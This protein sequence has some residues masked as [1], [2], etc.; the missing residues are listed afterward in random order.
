MGTGILNTIGTAVLRPKGEKK[1]KAKEISFHSQ[2]ALQT[3][4]NTFILPA[5]RLE[6]LQLSL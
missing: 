6:G 5:G 1:K 4:V 2:N 3:W